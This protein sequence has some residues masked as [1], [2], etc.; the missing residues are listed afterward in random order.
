MRTGSIQEEAKNR[1]SKF[2]VTWNPFVLYFGGL[3]LQNQ[4]FSNQNKGHLGSRNEIKQDR[5]K[6][7]IRNKSCLFFVKAVLFPCFQRETA[8]GYGF[9]YLMISWSSF[10]YVERAGTKASDLANL[11]RKL[12][13]RPA[14]YVK[15]L[16]KKWQTFLGRLILG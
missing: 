2:T 9:G 10:V 14:D 5:N 4:A 3:I 8:V 6:K 1:V 7:E 13:S 11:A 12:V 16:T 15:K